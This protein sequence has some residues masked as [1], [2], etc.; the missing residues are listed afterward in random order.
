MTPRINAAPTMFG[1]KHQRPERQ[2]RTSNQ[3]GVFNQA[4]RTLAILL[5]QRIG[6][7]NAKKCKETNLKDLRQV[8]GN[9]RRVS[10]HE[11]HDVKTLRDLPAFETRRH[12][13]EP[14][15]PAAV[16]AARQTGGVTLES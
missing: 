11:W 6:G 14:A 8:P 5:D 2:Y 9:K 7:V 12:R 15:I 3:D 16:K 4:N 13:R 1:H 10:E